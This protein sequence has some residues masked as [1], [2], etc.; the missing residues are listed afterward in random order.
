MSKYNVFKSVL[1]SVF[2]FGVS[3][4]LATG[5]AHINKAKADLRVEAL[6]RKIDVRLEENKL[7]EK[8]NAA[9][10]EENKKAEEKKAKIAEVIKKIDEKALAERL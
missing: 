5:S 3:S 4:L 10:N 9:Y 8:K 7:L 1:L 2:C 6:E